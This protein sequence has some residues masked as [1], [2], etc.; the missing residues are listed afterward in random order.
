MLRMKNKLFM[1]GIVVSLVLTACSPTSPL[2]GETPTPLPAETSQVQPSP[3][4]TK[5][6]KSESDNQTGVVKYDLGEA[7]I[8]QPQFAHDSAF[9][10]MPVRLNGII[11]VPD[12]QDGPYPVV[13]I[14]HGTHPG[15][16]EDEMGVDRWPCDPEVEQPNYRGFEYLVGELAQRG[17]VALSIN[18]NAENTFGFGEPIPGERLEQL[19]DLHL[20]ALSEAA[21]GGPNGFGVELKGRADLSKLVFFGHSRGSEGAYMLSE[22]PNSLVAASQAYGPIRGLLLIAPAVIMFDPASGSS[23]VPMGIILPACDGDVVAQDGQF[24]YEGARLAPGQS[25]WVNSA[26]LERAN[27]NYFNQILPDDPFGRRGRPDCE[28]ILDEQEQRDWLV[29]YASDFLTLILSPDSAEGRAAWKR[30]GMEAQDPATMS[31]YGL[32]GRVAA[33]PAAADRVRVLAPVTEDELT[34]NLAGGLVKTEGVSTHFCPAGYYSPETVPGSEPCRRRNVTIPGQPSLAVVSWEA[35]GGTW[36]FSLPESSRNLSAFTAL[37]LRAAVDPLSSLN[38]PDKP[39]S[40]SVQL[41]D[42][43]GNEAV[44]QTRP[45]EPALLFPAGNREDID[46]DFG[47]IFTGRV[48]LTTIRL[49]LDDF[50]GVDLANIEN[51]SLIFDQTPS[52]A[53]FMADIEWVR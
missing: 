48:P 5:V 38:E 8:V 43:D 25:E 49:Q 31:L 40:F 27:H 20:K 22:A 7:T 6:S 2:P 30:I 24:F 35:S 21:A 3:T 44:V 46:W 33:L 15:C 47:E 50:V 53:L 12:A 4:P 18:I 13:V 37:S 17:Y 34:T 39:Q 28:P 29:D 32:A 1:I 16:P 45:D 52:G 9:Y 36:S 10:F 51:I 11:A 23:D 14:L 41:T 42:K 26:W 19:V